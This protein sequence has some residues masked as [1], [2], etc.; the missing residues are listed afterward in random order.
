MVLVG[1]LGVAHVTMQQPHRT[2]PR[3]SVVN[4]SAIPHWRARGEDWL[5][6]GG[7][8]LEFRGWAEGCGFMVQGVGFG[9]WGFGVWGL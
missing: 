3:P 6:F 9:S 2:P 4:F 5:G 1:W 7:S 8:G